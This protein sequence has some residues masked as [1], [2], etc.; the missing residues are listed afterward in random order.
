MSEKEAPV[1][2]GPIAGLTLSNNGIA[3]LRHLSA[4]LSGL[5][6]YVHQSCSNVGAGVLFFDRVADVTQKLFAR[7]RGL[8][9]V[10]PVGVVVRS[11]A[12]C[13]SHKLSDP[14]IVVTDVHARWAVSLLSGHEGGA[15]RLADQ[16]SWILDAEPVITTTS[17]AARNV[18]AGVG[19]RR[20]TSADEIVTALGASLTDA[21]YGF[22]DVRLI[23]SADIKIDEP[24]IR[25]AACQLHTGLRFISSS[26][27]SSSSRDF[28]RSEFVKSKINLPAVAE[29][30]ALLAGNRT[31][32]IS[33]KKK[34]KNVTIALALERS[35]WSE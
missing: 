7:Y 2:E 22:D 19:C 32:L 14:A 11:I 6:I 34:Y 25:Q 1:I 3:L 10:M 12:P 5:E 17:E 16:V 30:S 15:N 18:I 31:C 29:P 24:G 8:I 35:M 28:E 27:I 9:Y 20:G 21:G 23:A 33:K 4:K 13:V 26:A